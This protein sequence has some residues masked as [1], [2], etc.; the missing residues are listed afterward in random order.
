MITGAILEEC[1]G[2]LSTLR[3]FPSN[4]FA[5][6]AIGE[7]IREVCATDNDGLSLCRQVLKTS[8]D[9]L[10]PA[11]IYKTQADLV[12]QRQEAESKRIRSERVVAYRGEREIHEATCTGY[13]VGLDSD[14]QTVFVQFCNERWGDWSDGVSC[15]KG[16]A[17]SE[18]D[19]GLCKRLLE[20][21]LA[22]RNG[23]MSEDEW[24]R[25][26]MAIKKARPKPSETD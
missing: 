20:K 22:N 17:L 7:I 8:N 23:W 13:E 3:Y 12:E 26:K 11:T 6:E 1:L 15:R 14:K 24:W 19:P 9:W 21:E 2:R 25:M 5:I 18:S 4:Q 10:G 16:S